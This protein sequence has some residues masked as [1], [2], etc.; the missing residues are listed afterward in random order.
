MPHVSGMILN[1]T[2]KYVD[3]T[4]LYPTVNKHDKYMVRHSEIIVRN[5]K[6]I[7]EYFVIAQIDVI[8]SI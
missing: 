6:P 1:E 3:F 7:S 4:P 5:F 8:P 2:T